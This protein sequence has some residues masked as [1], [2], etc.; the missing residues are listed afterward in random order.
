MNKFLGEVEFM[1]LFEDLL[2]VFQTVIDIKIIVDHSLNQGG[3]RG[4]VKTNF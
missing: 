1:D 2:S 3:K 4:W